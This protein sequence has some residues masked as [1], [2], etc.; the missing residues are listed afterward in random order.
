LLSDYR[1]D[2]VSQA[3]NKPALQVLFKSNFKYS[4]NH[5][6]YVSTFFSNLEYLNDKGTEFDL[7]LGTQFKQQDY[8]FDIGLLNNYAA[9]IDTLDNYF[10]EAYFGVSWANKSTYFI[11]ADDEDSFFGGQNAKVIWDQYFALDPHL[12]LSYQLGYNNMLKAKTVDPDYFWVSTGISYT[13]H[14]YKLSLVF[15]KTDISK[16]EDPADI[17]QSNIALIGSYSF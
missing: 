3:Q 2:G 14:A 15:Y 1:S 5:S 12:K 7:A 16:R 11:Y 10:L 17:A 8:T 13:Q 9:H 4:E 6:F